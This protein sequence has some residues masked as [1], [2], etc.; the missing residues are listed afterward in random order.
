MKSPFFLH[1]LFCH[2]RQV[3]TIRLLDLCWD[4][5]IV[6]VTAARW[7]AACDRLACLWPVVV[8]LE[9]KMTVIVGL[10]R[11]INVP[12]VDP[13]GIYT[14]V[15]K[16]TEPGWTALAEHDENQFASSLQTHSLSE[17]KAK[18]HCCNSSKWP[19][20]CSHDYW[21]SLTLSPCLPLFLSL[22]SLPL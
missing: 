9:E 1:F 22:P 2:R 18:L 19:V 16:E 10:K 17:M 20:P 12:L 8:L 7:W 3:I 14:A 13:E 15:F 6:M 21:L 4:R 5:G 11:S